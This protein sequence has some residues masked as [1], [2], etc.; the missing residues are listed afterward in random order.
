MTTDHLLSPLKTLKI[1]LTISSVLTSFTFGLSIGSFTSSLS[2]PSNYTQLDNVMYQRPEC[3]ASPDWATPTAFNTQDC[4]AALDRFYDFIFPQRFRAY[5]EFRI[6]STPAQTQLPQV[7]LS[8]RFRFNTCSLGVA[9]LWGI[10][11]PLPGGGG[12]PPHGYPRNDVTTWGDIYRGMDR[13][14]KRCALNPG[15]D[16]GGWMKVGDMGAIGVF[17]VQADSRVDGVIR[18]SV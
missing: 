8:R 2:L 13:V 7:F 1:A 17:V 18:D 16:T 11:I 10:R 5:N 6:A 4:L 15:M 3:A 12:D 9:M 14:A